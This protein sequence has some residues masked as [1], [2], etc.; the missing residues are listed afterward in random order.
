MGLAFWRI[1]NEKVQ[2]RLVEEKEK[3]EK[4]A[5]PES[6]LE[7]LEKD[8]RKVEVNTKKPEASAEKE[9]KRAKDKEGRFLPDN[10]A[11]PEVNEAYDPPKPI[12]AQL[13]TRSPQSHSRKPEQS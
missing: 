3:G 4:A 1:Y 5:R 11:T 7:T 12:K 10:L 13:A 6:P 2:Q 8:L 9:Y